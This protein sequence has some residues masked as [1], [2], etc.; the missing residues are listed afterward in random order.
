MSTDSILLNAR[1]SEFRLYLF[2]A[3]VYAS[4]AG[5][6][7]MPTISKHQ[8]QLAVNTQ[9]SQYLKQASSKNA[10]AMPIV[11]TP[12]SI[13]IQRLGIDLP[14]APGY[15]NF[16]THKWTLDS[17]H[18]FTDNFTDPNPVVGSKQAR[19]TV[20][21]G[22]DIPGILVKTSQLV[23]GDILAITT[24]N[25]YR[26]RYYY[27]R[28]K[29][30]VPTDTSILSEQNTGDPV[31]LVTCTGTWYQFR[32]AMYFRLINVQKLPDQPAGASA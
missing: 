9:L 6:I 12:A 23:H 16:S 30:I 25:G 1:S 28:S 11:G 32:H 13:S 5:L 14:V 19:V 17:Q 31:I 2:A 20:L 29:V 8:T 3:L 21:Y 7:L 24:K 15:Y 4:V 22:H 10:V 26:F 18:V 27:D